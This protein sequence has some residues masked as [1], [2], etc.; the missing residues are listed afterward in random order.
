MYVNP[1]SKAKY[2]NVGDV[3]K[4]S[5]NNE[6]EVVSFS[7]VFADGNVVTVSFI[8]SDTLPAIDSDY[9]SIWYTP[10]QLNFRTEVNTD[11]TIASQLLFDAQNYEYTASVS[12]NASQ[13]ANKAVVG[14]RIVDASGFEYEIT[15]LDPVLRF[16]ANIRIKEVEKIGQPPTA[17]SA[18]LYRPMGS[19][20]L[21]QGAALSAP[22]LA[23]V[24]NR[25]NAILENNLGGGS[26]PTADRFIKIGVNNSGETIPA[27]RLVSRLANG[28]LV[29]A[30]SD[31]ASG[32]QPFAV[33]QEEILDG[34]SGEVLLMGPNAE[35]ALTG[36]GFTTGDS[37]YL[38]EDASFTNDANSF[39]GED[40][41]IIKVGIADCASG[42][43]SGVATDLILLREVILRP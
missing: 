2:L 21:Y 36:L 40:D 34:A 6:Y 41:S 32:Q 16:N 12:W 20:G 38:S 22:V 18:T 27:N 25:D 4:D 14:D 8:T 42:I 9:N 17:G 1:S 19:Y 35:G 11:G 30:D 39:T 24:R 15:F 5:V 13:Q 3:V 7:G 37:I 23:K 29:I 10:G 33:T 26:A 31:S 28:S 43:A